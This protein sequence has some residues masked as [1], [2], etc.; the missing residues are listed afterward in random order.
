MNYS[1][2]YHHVCQAAEEKG[3]TIDEMLAQIRS[4]GIGCVEMDRDAV[5]QEDAEILALGR[6]L[7]A[8]GLRV[9]SIY[10]FYD[11]GSG[12]LPA[13]DDLLLRQAELLGC[14]RVMLIPGFWTDVQNAEKCR[15][16]TAAMIA[17]MKRMAELAVARG[18]TP[19][20]ECFDDARSPI[21]TIRGMAEFL[22]AVPQLMVTLE[23]GNFLFS[24]DDIL[25]AQQRF[26]D[27]VR[28]VHLKDRFLPARAPETT[29]AGNPVTSVTG[30]VMYPCAVGSG[31]IPVRQVICELARRGYEGVMT[32]EHFGAADYAETIRRS[33]SWLREVEKC[34]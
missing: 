21:A 28:H 23:T 17:G 33:I 16:E 30:E 12:V 6:R 29:P 13:E 18:L 14:S 22:E 19:T 25:E 31:H 3:C 10:G 4:W 2:F 8:Q 34:L 11:W 15:Q 1:V 24:G 27:R 26:G 9:S 7:T 32:I 5:G 20:I